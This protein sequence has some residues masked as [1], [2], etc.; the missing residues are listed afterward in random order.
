MR[1]LEDGNDL[2]PGNRA[3]APVRLLNQRFER[4]LADSHRPQGRPPEY[5]SHNHAQA[6][7]IQEIFSITAEQGS[8]HCYT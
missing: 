8:E 5:F 2:G 6:T 3:A 4:G 1:G 7:V